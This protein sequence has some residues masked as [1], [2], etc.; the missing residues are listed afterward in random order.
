MLK[1]NIHGKTNEDIM[2]NLRIEKWKVMAKC[3][4]QME[5]I[6]KVSYNCKFRLILK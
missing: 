6:I 5:S 4:G 1:G 2:V 3:I